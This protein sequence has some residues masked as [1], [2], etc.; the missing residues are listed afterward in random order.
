MHQFPP[1]GAS[2][3][4]PYRTPKGV[5]DIA[6][7]R[8]VGSSQCEAG[9]KVRFLRIRINETEGT[10]EGNGGTFTRFDKHLKKYAENKKFENNCFRNI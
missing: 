8:Q 10:T 3:Y 2:A 5:G 4:L 9:I 7:F 1:G 6:Q